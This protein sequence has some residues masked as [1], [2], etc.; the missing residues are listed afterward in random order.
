MSCHVSTLSNIPVPHDNE[1]LVQLSSQYPSIGQHPVLHTLVVFPIH[2][3]PPEGR[4]NRLIQLEHWQ[5]FG[6]RENYH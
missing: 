4:N 1:Q 6:N 2:G 3:A 5:G